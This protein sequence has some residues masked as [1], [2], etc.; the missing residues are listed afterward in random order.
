MP[1]GSVSAVAVASLAGSASLPADQTALATIDDLF[2]TLVAGF[3]LAKDN[4]VTTVNTGGI[5]TGVFQN[6]TKVVYAMRKLA[7]THVG[8][9]LNYYGLKATEQKNWGSVVGKI[10]AD[11]HKSSTKT[12]KH[13]LE[14][15]H[16]NLQ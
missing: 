15:A 10:E 11:Y 12:V 14:L 16:G 13:L 9:D 4:K 8:V 1:Q 7:A 3:K 6:S 5:G 2:N